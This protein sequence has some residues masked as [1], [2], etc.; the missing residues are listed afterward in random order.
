[1]PKTLDL[2]PYRLAFYASELNEPPHVHVHR[3][4]YEAKFWLDPVELARHSRFPRHELTKIRKL[5][6]ANQETLLEKWYAF[7]DE[8][9]N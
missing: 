5:V 2:G 9:Q 4:R 6:L 3:D 8:T 1:M 7:F